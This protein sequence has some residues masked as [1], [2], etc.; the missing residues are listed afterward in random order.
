MLVAQ[1]SLTLCVPIEYSPPASSVPG[2]LQARILEWVADLPS[3]RIKP[4]FPALQADSL[5]S[6]PPGKPKKWLVYPL[7][8]TLSPFPEVGRRSRCNH[9][10]SFLSML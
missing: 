6:E 5:P 9:S 1:S 3:S 10:Q 4:R 7:N 2:I 8:L